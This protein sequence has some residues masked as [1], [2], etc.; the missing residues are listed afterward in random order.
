M[1]KLHDKSINYLIYLGPQWNDTII[2][3]YDYK[4]STPLNTSLK[5]LLLP[6]FMY[7]SNIPL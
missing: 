5:T 3:W 2:R 4:S 1:R 6:I 7:S